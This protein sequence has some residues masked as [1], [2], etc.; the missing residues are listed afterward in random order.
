MTD[1]TNEQRPTHETVAAVLEGGP[2][3]LPAAERSRRVAARDDKIKIAYL[4]GYEHFA[5]LPPSQSA[6]AA[7]GDQTAPV[8]YR[9]TART[10][11]A[12]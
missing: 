12:E 6:A 11:I 5:R 1:L 7:E 4:G 8:V 10:L 3:D 2:A 9:W